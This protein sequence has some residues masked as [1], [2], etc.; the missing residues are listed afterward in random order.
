[1]LQHEQFPGL[2]LRPLPARVK[3]QLVLTQDL[4]LFQQAGK[5]AADEYVMRESNQNGDLS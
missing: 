4:R 1:M 5:R 3:H 2:P